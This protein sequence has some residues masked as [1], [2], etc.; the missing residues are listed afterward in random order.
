[1][2]DH[3][4]GLHVTFNYLCVCVRL[5]TSVILEP[6][7]FLSLY[8]HLIIPMSM[9]SGDI[10]TKYC[11]IFF[12]RFNVSACLS[13]YYFRTAQRIFMK[14]DII[15][16]HYNLS[17]MNKIGQKCQTSYMKTCM[18]LCAHLELNCA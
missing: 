10:A 11:E 2:K 13:V 1:M 3:V 14:S 17:I 7:Y 16:F 5:I 8:N 18:R 12:V 6:M 9:Y 4:A 15:E